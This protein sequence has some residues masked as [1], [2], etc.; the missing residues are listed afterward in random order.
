MSLLN[1]LNNK[2][3]YTFYNLLVSS[4]TK[5]LYEKFFKNCKSN[6]KILDIGI[7]NGYAIIQNEKIIK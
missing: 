7:G 6:A 3:N 4:Y 5:N 2:L 1:D